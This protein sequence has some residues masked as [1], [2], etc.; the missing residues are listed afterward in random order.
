MLTPIIHTKGQ[1]QLWKEQTK[2]IANSNL[3]YSQWTLKL[4]GRAGRK[5]RYYI[6]QSKSISLV[7][8]VVRNLSVSEETNP[9]HAY[10]IFV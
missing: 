10:L 7:G 9:P 4:G 5:S 2:V 6:A 3:R 1:A 8:S